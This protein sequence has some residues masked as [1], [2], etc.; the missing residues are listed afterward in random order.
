MEGYCLSSTAPAVTTSD[1]M[2]RSRTSISQAQPVVQVGESTSTAV[3]VSLPYAKLSGSSTVYEIASPVFT[4]G[5]QV[6]LGDE[7]MT[8]NLTLGLSPHLGYL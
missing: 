2:G 8:R 6:V 3:Y 7:V 5:Q 1:V 4:L